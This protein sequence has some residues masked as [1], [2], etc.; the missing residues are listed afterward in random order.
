MIGVDR[1]QSYLAPEHVLTSA[2]KNVKVA[3]RSV[4]ESFALGVKTGGSNLSLGLTEGAV[5]IPAEHKN[6]RDEIYDATLLVED[7]IK[8]GQLKP[9]ATE[10]EYADFLESLQ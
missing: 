10:E 9:P 2:L 6:Y 3:V 7:S 4:S 5:G 1:D 8:A